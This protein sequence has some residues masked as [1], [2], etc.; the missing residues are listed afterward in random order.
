MWFIVCLALFFSSGHAAAVGVADQIELF[1]SDAQ[2]VVAT[3]DNTAKRQAEAQLILDSVS[4]RILEL[5][6][7][8]DHVTVLKIPLVPPKRLVLQSAGLDTELVDMF[9]VM[10]KRGERQPWL[11]LHTKQYETVVVEFSR[12]VKKLKELLLLP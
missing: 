1:D 5:N 10:P 11:I 9:V 12:G 3:F 8:L 4:G 6:P 2:K 7:S